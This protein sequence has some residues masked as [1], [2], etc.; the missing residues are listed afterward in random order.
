MY[1]LQQPQAPAPAPDI[2]TAQLK[3]QIKEQVR[4]A[5]IDARNAATE[6]AQ[7]ARA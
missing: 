5:T 6:A 3:A 4:Q 7:A 1:N 2:S